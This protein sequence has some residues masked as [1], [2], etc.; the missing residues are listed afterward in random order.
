MGGFAGG[1]EG[2]F[3]DVDAIDVLIAKQNSH[4]IKSKKQAKVVIETKNSAYYIKDDV[5]ISIVPHNTT[6]FTIEG[7]DDI[8]LESNTIYKTYKALMELTCASDIEDFFAEH[9]VLL[10]QYTPTTSSTSFLLLVKE[11]CNL[12]LSDSE[13]RTIREAAL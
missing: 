9:K 10:T 3:W 4:N 11:L 8:P 2:G 12:I 5:T 6:A 13:L 7:C 1:D